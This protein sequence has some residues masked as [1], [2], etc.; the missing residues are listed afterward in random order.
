MPNAKIVF[1]FLFFFFNTLSGVEEDEGR[2]RDEKR[3]WRTEQRTTL[4]YNFSY[5]FLC[6]KFSKLPRRRWQNGKWERSFRIKS[7]TETERGAASA[8]KLQTAKEAE[9]ERIQ[10]QTNAKG[11]FRLLGGVTKGGGG[12]GCISAPNI[13]ASASVSV[14][15]AVSVAVSGV[16]SMSQSQWHADKELQRLKC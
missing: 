7:E 2:P 4:A 10:R 16:V 9:T 8:T 3:G 12:G 13:F 15:V 11:K 14:S 1:Q 6:E 5:Y